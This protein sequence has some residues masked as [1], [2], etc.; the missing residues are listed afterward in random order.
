MHRAGVLSAGVLASSL[1]VT[2]C[3]RGEER[4]AGRFPVQY[5]VRVHGGSAGVLRIRY[6]D[7]AGPP[8]V[9]EV[10]AKSW[11]SEE[12]SF[13]YGSPIEL[14]V[15]LEAPGQRTIQCTVRTR[16]ADDPDGTVYGGGGGTSCSI[17]EIAGVNP[18]SPD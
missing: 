6:R 5:E 13:P 12:M 10:E 2:A 3:D 16:T 18:F 8:A 17:Q 1:L 11:T 7:E 14:A 15:E 9:L 4:P